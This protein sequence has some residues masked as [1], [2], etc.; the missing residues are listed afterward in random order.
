METNSNALADKQKQNEPPL[1]MVLH[2][3][4]MIHFK[5]ST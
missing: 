1:E 5:A 4:L 2:F 3:S